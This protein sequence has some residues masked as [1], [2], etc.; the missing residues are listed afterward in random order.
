MNLSLRYVGLV[1]GALALIPRPL[2]GQ[3][4]QDAEHHHVMAG[5]YYAREVKD[6]EWHLRLVGEIP[7]LCG[8]YIVIHDAAGKIVYHGVIPHGQYPADRPYVVAIKPDGTVG[9]YK[10]VMVGHQNDLLGVTVPYTDLPSEVYGG[11]NFTI[12]HEPDVEPLFRAPDGVT[13]MSLG[14]YKGH[15]KVADQTGRV[16][17]D[18]RVGGVLKKYD[19]TTDFDVKPGDTYR[20][21]LECFYFRSYLPGTLFIAFDPA[22]WFSPTAALDQV[23]WW[24]GIKP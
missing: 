10:I 4:V 2:P 13:K 19:M 6:Q 12:G 23:K 15:L 9:D 24:E 17:A 14:A 7:S 20:L 22:R 5:G 16:V 11:A 8:A 18:T 1:L 3:A 21:Q